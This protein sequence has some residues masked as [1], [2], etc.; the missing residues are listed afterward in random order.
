MLELAS[1]T[2]QHVAHFAVELD[3]NIV[4]QPSEYDVDLHA[5]VEARCR[6]LENVLSPLKVD[7]R[8]NNWVESSYD[9]VLTANLLHI[10][11]PEVSEALFCGAA[12]HLKPDGQLIIYGPFKEDGVHNSDGNIAFDAQL[13]QQN[14]QW[15]IRDIAWL[16]MLASENGLALQQQQ[17]MPANN[18]MLQ[19]R[20]G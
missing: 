1:G 18:R 13:R 8:N 15:G 19:F 16:Q 9:V 2:G 6:S 10:S 4:W 20:L 7:V 14:A 3:A 11:E 5:D 12:A 17:A